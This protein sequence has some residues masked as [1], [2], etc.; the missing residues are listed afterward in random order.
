MRSSA[1]L[2]LGVLAACGSKT[3]STTTPKKPLTAKEIVERSSPAIVRVEV[4]EGDSRGVGTGF[5]LDKGGLIATNLHVVVG[6][7]DIKVKLYGGEVYPVTQIV[8][9]DPD[10]DLALLRIAPP[11]QL[12]TLQLGD[13]D[14]MTAGDQIVAIGNPL[15]HDYSVSS[16]LVSKIQP[17]CTDA[18]VALHNANLA[19]FEELKAKYFAR[20][21]TR[22]EVGELLKL[23]CSAELRYIQISAPISQGSSGGPVFNLQGEV[24]GVTTAI[25]KEGQNLNYAV[26]VNY[27]KPIITKPVSLSVDEFAKQ[28]RG[29]EV[30]AVDDGEKIERKVPDHGL[31]VL[32]GCK[33]EQVGELVRTIWD[34]IE[35]GAPIYNKAQEANSIDEKKRY[36]EACFRI[37]E[38][39]ANKFEQNPPCKGVKKAFADGLERAKTMDSYKL[40]AWAMRDTFDGLIKVAEKYANAN[41]GPP[42]KQ[43]KK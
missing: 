18:D 22:D 21:I 9:F 34:A 20:T 25:V 43:P 14:K 36:Y 42:L 19:R 39:T 15:G 2:L 29:P 3:P 27:L 13:S 16:G 24:V 40:K 28:T 10:R 17:E 12:P 6:S 33:R 35:V 23:R 5:I 30:A 8:G 37:Y 38:G 1:W 41:P 31:E 4:A 26:P 32:D 7:A 11:K